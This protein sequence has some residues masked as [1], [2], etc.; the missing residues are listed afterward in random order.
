MGHDDEAAVI[1]EIDLESG[2]IVKHFSLGEPAV[3][4]DFEGLAIDGDGVFYLITSQGR[5]YRFRE[6]EAR[7]NV[8]FEAFDTGLATVAEI[9][10]LTFHYGEERLILASKTNFAPV[11]QATLA[12]YQWAPE[13]PD[14]PARPWLMAPIEPLAQAVGMS[15]FHPSGMEIDQRTG[16]LVLLAGREGGLVELDRQGEV[17]AS[18]GLGDLHPHAEGVTILADGGMLI[19]DEGGKD[20]AH[21]TRYDRAD[22]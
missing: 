22:G 18:R 19:S 2:A 9:E 4:G 12:L 13:R 16:R 3:R 1:Y 7:A 6:G 8:P 5:L 21:L 10:G 14:Q 20:R 17:L 11:M 15:G